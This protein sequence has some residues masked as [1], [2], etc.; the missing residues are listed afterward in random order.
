MGRRAS[1][2]ASSQLANPYVNSYHDC[3]QPRLLYRLRI[4]GEERPF[5]EG[6]Q[7]LEGPRASPDRRESVGVRCLWQVST[8][9]HR[10]T[11][12][13]ADNPL[14]ASD[15]LVEDQ[16][17]NTGL[18]KIPGHEIVG[19]VV[20]VHPSDRQFKVGDRVGSGWHGSHCGTCRWC[21]A[22][23]FLMCE[24]EGIDGMCHVFPCLFPC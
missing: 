15:V 20:A 6:P 16:R 4:Q 13:E 14:A 8:R 3:S 12:S 17:L 18:P 2:L 19:D 10:I 11:V 1:V 23:D 5:G 21:R 7:A 24:N 9:D 22:G